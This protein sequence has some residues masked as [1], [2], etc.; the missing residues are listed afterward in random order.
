MDKLARFVIERARFSLLLVF[1]VLVAG[2]VVYQTQPRQEDPEIKV[3]GAQ[4]VAQFQGM[5][6]ERVEQLLIRPIEEAIKEI[7]EI[8]EIKSLAMTG[9]AIISPEVDSQYDDL[10]PI[11][12]TLR[13]KMED[14]QASLPDGT[15]GPFVNDDF[16]RVAVV[17]L[18]LT[19]ND[20]SM[21]EL[22]DVAEDVG[23]SMS[24]LPLVARTDLYGVQEETIWLELDPDFMAQL[25]LTTTA[26]VQAIRGQNVVMSGGT[27]NADGQNLVIEP[28]GD[29]ESLDQIRNLPISTKEGGLVYLQDLATIT[30]SYNDPPRSPAYFNNQPAIVLGISMVTSSNVVELGH[31]VTERLATLRPQL[32]VGMKLDVAIFQPDLVEDSVSSAT[33]NL[34]QTV[35]VVLVV[36]ML[37]LGLRTGLIV[38]A[39]VPLTMMVTL[40]GMSIW[41]IELHRISIAAIIVALGLLVD[42]GVVVA[43]EI[44]QRLD[45]GVDRLEAAL[46]TPRSLAIPLLTSS[47]T[48]VVAFMP[49]VLIQDTTGEFL[50]SLGQVL[51]IAL[52]AS[53]LLSISITPAMCY[54]FL[55]DKI[56]D[57]KVEA[58]SEGAAYSLYRGTL[59]W[60]LSHRVVIG[61]IVVVML[62]ATGLVFQTVKQR[63]LGPSERNQFV[64][65]VDLPAE[66]AISETIETTRRLSAFLSDKARN[67]EVTDVLSYVGSGGPRFFLALSPNDPQPNKAFMVVNTETDKQIQTVMQRTD[68]Y[69]D[70]GLP[71]ASGRSEVLFLGPAALGTVE[72]RIVG[73]SIDDLR[74]IGLDVRNVFYSVPGIQAVRSDWENSVLKIRVEIDQE[75]ARRNGITSEQVAM[76]LSGFFDGTVAT[77]YREGENVIPVSIRASAENRNSLDRLRTIELQSANGTPVPLI[78]IARFEG[79]IEPSRVRRVNQERALSVFAKHPN[80]TAVELY[81]VIEQQVEQLQLPPGYRIELEGEIKGAAESN[82]KLMGF[83]PHA[84]FIIVLLLVLQFDSFR[85]PAIII[86][87]IPLVVVGAIFGLAAFRAYFDFTAM[88]GLFSLAGIII[89]NGIVMIDRID[90]NREAGHEVQESIVEAAL[91]R[92]RPIVMTTITTV[93]GLLPL[94]LF[95]GEF[96]YGMAIVIMCGLAVGTLL[97]L[98]Y[99]PVLYSA[100]FRSSATAA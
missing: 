100:F 16:G 77:H 72:L 48:T 70:T 42:N 74:R 97:T 3:R 66:A 47:L 92:A 67:P 23:A 52:L 58:S 54:W 29:F 8:K 30:R 80:M 45:N 75:R 71:Q 44:R 2:L 37:F 14:L 24:T 5:S 17:T 9:T 64:V 1:S 61:V 94:A 96:W 62:I 13:N 53:W 22:A 25:D 73:P 21:A 91:T 63:S 85:R 86:L 89:N 12:A 50:R 36:V 49:L 68:R 87:T 4:V 28:S 6:P 65:Y 33:S 81:E 7:P 38:G 34:L 39:M 88:L 55:D 10:D 95:G 18:A 46:A 19:G 27:I 20:F 93:V 31:Q 41:G 69:F 51:A 56:A 84:L 60:A 90:Q 83:A 82:S 78:Q 59:V 98:I 32:P 40:V 79:E 99:V 35:V 15:Q 57:K 26:I 11:W 76:T 43:E